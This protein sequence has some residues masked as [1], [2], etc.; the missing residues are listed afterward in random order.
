MENL[1]AEQVKRALAW[2]IQSESCEYCEYKSAEDIDVCGIR[3]D[4]LAL[5]KSQEQ[6][7]EELAEENEKIGIENF[8]LICE[9]SRIK[10]DTVRK[11]LDKIEEHA[12]NSYPRK[13]RLD[14][15]DQIAKEVLG[16]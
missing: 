3:S 13:V 11:M 16:E 9:L 10:E 5:I 4:A 2:C 7:I 1:N 14:V 8:D 15:I 6:R 12:S